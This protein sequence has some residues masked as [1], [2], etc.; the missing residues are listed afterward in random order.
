M[1][2]ALYS[3]MKAAAKMKERA[4]SI[5]FVDEAFE[6]AAMRN[7]LEK[8]ESQRGWSDEESYPALRKMPMVKSMKLDMFAQQWMVK[9]ELLTRYIFWHAYCLVINNDPTT[10]Q[11]FEIIAP[12]K[13]GWE[14]TTASIHE[15][16][17]SREWTFFRSA[18][19]KFV[20][21]EKSESGSLV[22]IW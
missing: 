14:R 4:L 15:K 13:V 21:Q 7:K 22:F 10:D 8:A 11:V 20:Y 1:G 2:L 12:A 9:A 5:V 19:L 6:R 16:N 3:R 18:E 17:I